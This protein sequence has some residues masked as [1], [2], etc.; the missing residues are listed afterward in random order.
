MIDTSYNK[1]ILDNNSLE[2]NLSASDIMDDS[3]I[4]ALDNVDSVLSEE[5]YRYFI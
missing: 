3:D 2:Q 1:D 5:G 4:T